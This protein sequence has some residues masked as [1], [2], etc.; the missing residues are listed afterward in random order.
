MQAINEK[1][2]RRF[3]RGAEELAHAYRKEVEEAKQE[4]LATAHQI[5]EQVGVYGLTDAK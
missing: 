2:F 3:Q 4:S 5:W 1:L